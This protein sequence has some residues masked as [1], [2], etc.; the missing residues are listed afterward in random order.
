MIRPFPTKSTPMPIRTRFAITNCL[1]VVWLANRRLKD[2][3]LPAWL[4]S[5]SSSCLLLRRDYSSSV[6]VLIETQLYLSYS[7][8]YRDSESIARIEGLQLLGPVLAVG[9]NVCDDFRSQRACRL[10]HLSGQ[11]RIVRRSGNHHAA[12][13]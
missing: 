7:A 12:N 10:A 5:L 11:G 8:R 9:F 1:F 4:G 6:L 2:R 13:A 3:I